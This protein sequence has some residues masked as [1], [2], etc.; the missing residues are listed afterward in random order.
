M[1]K[2]LSTANAKTQKGVKEGYLTFILHLAPADL[3]GVG[4]T[5]P[6]ASPGC[7]AACLNTA[8][9][10]GMFKPGEN[11]NSVQKARIRKT[12]DFFT[13]QEQFMLDLVADIDFAIRQAAK[14]KLTPV[15]RLNATS[16]IAWE[17]KSIGVYPNIFAM[18]PNIQFYDYTKIVGRKVKG[19]PNY[20][21]TFSRAEDND[22]DVIKAA[23]AGLNVTVVFDKV[24]ALYKG[25]TVF[26]GDKNDLR[27]LDPVSS[28][29]GLKAKGRGRKDTTGFVVTTA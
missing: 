20:H 29:I 24:P 27:F 9:H 3:S 16:D 14:V 17:K 13:N 10:G 22:K 2:L 28:I 7:K 18:F 6:K 5:C 15:I 12:I 25:H 4:N 19:I 21:L 8:G 23:A 11:T 1:L 26:S